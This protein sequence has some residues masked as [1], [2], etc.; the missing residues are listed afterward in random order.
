MYSAGGGFLGKGYAATLD[1]IEAEVEKLPGQNRFKTSTDPGTVIEAYL[2]S[3]E[4][5]IGDPDLPLLT[6][7]SR[8][9]R[10]EKPQNRG[11]LRRNFGYY[12]AASPYRLVEKDGFAFAIF[13]Q[14]TATLPIVLV[15]QPNGNWLVDEPLSWSLFQRYEDSSQVFVKYPGTLAKAALPISMPHGAPPTLT[16]DSMENLRTLEAAVAA[17]PD[18]THYLALADALYFDFYWLDAA[19]PLY[20]KA[21]LNGDTIDDHGMP[22]YVWHMQDA[23][24]A[25]SNI[26]GFLRTWDRLACVYRND[27][28]VAINR[29]FYH[30]SYDFS[31]WHYGDDMRSF[32]NNTFNLPL[33][34]GAFLYSRVWCPVLELWRGNS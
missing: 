3:L 10:I 21:F 9:F 20:E 30:A 15:G 5:G 28:D 22:E 13:K 2:N 14:N 29:Q 7:A 31:R 8:A 25:N 1:N 18:R 32:Q 26:E 4:Q 27:F 23:Y 6:T 33:I 24:L 19:I 12:Q 11:Q 34:A 16:P 17:Q